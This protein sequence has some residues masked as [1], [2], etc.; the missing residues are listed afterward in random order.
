MLFRSGAY[1]LVVPFRWDQANGQNDDIRIQITDQ[2][3][4][5]VEID[6]HYTFTGGR[7]D[8]TI[9][10][11]GVM[12]RGRKTIKF[13]FT[14]VGNTG[15]ITNIMAPTFNWVAEDY[16]ATKVPSGYLAMPGTLE[17]SSTYWT[18][19]GLRIENAGSANPNFGYASNGAS[20]TA[21]VYG[22]EAGVYSANIDF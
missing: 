6:Q 19:G 3:S 18:E 8:H 1:D 13:T 14:G 17:L 10:L 20:A 22:T 2:T 5:N 11:E 4:G 9:P 12:A 15:Y 7:N 21:K 16:D